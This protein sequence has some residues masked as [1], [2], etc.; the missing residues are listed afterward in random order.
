MLE[1]FRCREEGLPYVNTE[2]VDPAWAWEDVKRHPGLCAGNNAAAIE[3]FH[4]NET[5]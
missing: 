4:K 1:W 2:K 3:F 5:T